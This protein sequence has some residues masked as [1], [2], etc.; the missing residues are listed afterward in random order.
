MNAT[1]YIHKANTAAW[2]ALEN[3]SEWVNAMLKE[4]ASMEYG[5]VNPTAAQLPE[6][7]E[8]VEALGFTYKG[9]TGEGG[10][11]HSVSVIKQNGMSAQLDVKNGRVVV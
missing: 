8:Q 7:W 9:E 1:I 10:L 4:H 11:H 2:E 3:K 5:P 6:I